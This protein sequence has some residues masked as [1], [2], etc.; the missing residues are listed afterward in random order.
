L[1]VSGQSVGFINAHL[2]LFDDDAFTRHDGA[3]GLD[4]L[5]AAR[6]DLPIWFRHS[7]LVPSSDTLVFGTRPL[8]GPSFTP[9][10]HRADKGD[11]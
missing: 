9:S 11:A 10:V 6:E 4:D 5:A 2:V 8:T 7:H 1:L 3:K